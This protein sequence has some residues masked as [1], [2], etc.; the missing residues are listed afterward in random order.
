MTFVSRLKMLDEDYRRS[1]YHRKTSNESGPGG[2]LDIEKAR[3]WEIIWNKGR[4]QLLQKPVKTTMPKKEI[5]ETTRDATWDRRGANTGTLPN[6]P[7]GPMD[8]LEYQNNDSKIT[9]ENI[10]SYVSRLAAVLA[11]AMSFL[12]AMK[13]IKK[14]FPDIKMRFPTPPTYIWNPQKDAPKEAPKDK[15][16]EKEEPAAEDPDTD[17]PS[18]ALEPQIIKDKI[19]TEF[20]DLM[21]DTRMIDGVEEAVMTFDKD[22]SALFEIGQNAN[23]LTVT[24]TPS[25]DEQQDEDEDID[26]TGDEDLPAFTGKV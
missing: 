3:D 18:A 19:K 7:T 24:Y 23:H 5:P 21:W 20:P 25:P 26:D 10:V 2:G 8:R 14:L 17:D 1:S 9:E 4:A 6:D 16:G 15:K 13:I 12:E 11:R 22:D